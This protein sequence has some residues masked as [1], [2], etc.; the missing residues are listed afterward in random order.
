MGA[1][2]APPRV[3]TVDLDPRADPLAGAVAVGL[4]GVLTVGKV[5]DHL[6]FRSAGVLQ[7]GLPIDRPALI[8][9][10]A[11]FTTPAG[12]VTVTEVEGVL[13]IAAFRRADVGPE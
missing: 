6:P 12:I 11:N 5:A 13:A 2:E 7:A 9:Q 8:A 10:Q 1:L 3:P 4:T